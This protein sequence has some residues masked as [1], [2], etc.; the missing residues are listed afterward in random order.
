MKFSADSTNNNHKYVWGTAQYPTVTHTHTHTEPYCV[1]Y[2]FCVI[3]LAQ[4]FC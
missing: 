1:P 2:C 3:S 4:M